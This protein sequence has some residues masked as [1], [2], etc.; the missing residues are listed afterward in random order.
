MEMHVVF[1]QLVNKYMLNSIH[2]L[3]YL[4]ERSIVFVIRN[5]PEYFI[6][7]IGFVYLWVFFRASRNCILT[8]FLIPIIMP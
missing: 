6:Q 8:I 7:Y 4:Q 1:F 3:D 5:R 2:V